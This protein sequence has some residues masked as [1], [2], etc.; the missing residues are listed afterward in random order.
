MNATLGISSGPQAGFAA[1][2]VVAAI[3]LTMVGQVNNTPVTQSV[4]P[5]A[6]SATFTGLAAGDTYTFTAIPVDASDNP[7]TA[8]GYSP[9][10]ST[11]SVPAGPP[12]TVTLTVPQVLTSNLAP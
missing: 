2:S 1:G 7:L 5:D 4:A 6:T 3:L 8:A 9:P 10:S 11:L 12:A